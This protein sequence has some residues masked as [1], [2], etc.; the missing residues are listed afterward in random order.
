MSEP[1]WGP[2]KT[3]EFCRVGHG[4]DFYCFRYPPHQMNGWTQVE[5]DNDFRGCGEHRE[6]VKV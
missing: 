3:C 1:K 4:G 5:A 6:K 2:C